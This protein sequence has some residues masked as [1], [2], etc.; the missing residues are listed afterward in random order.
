M[1]AAVC[2]VVG[3]TSPPSFAQ[4]QAGKGP[5]DWKFTVAPYLMMPWMDGEVAVRGREVKVDVAPSEIFSNL[6]F[7][8]MGYFEARKSKWGVGVDAVYMA[9]GTTVDRDPLLGDRA[10]AD[11][12]LNQGAYAF[13]ALRELNKNVDFL[14]GV[15]WNVLDAR[16]GLKGPQQSVFEQTRQ[17]VD[18]I[19]GLKLKHRLGRRLNFSMQADI[20]GFGAGSDFAWQLLPMVGT[21]LGKH[22]TLGIGYRVLGSNYKTGSDSD[23]FKYDVITQAFVLGAAFHF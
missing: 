4:A 11:V 8:A 14:A 19:V 1:S 17:W 16:L 21:D 6:Q 22:T 9:L 3:L 15:R 18:P 23:Y 2:L 5:D 20:G 7:G 13:M 10:G 12:D